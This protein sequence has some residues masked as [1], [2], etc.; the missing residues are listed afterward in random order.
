MS[1]GGVF[2]LIANKGKSDSLL[3][4]TSLLNQRLKQC[5]CSRRENRQA[6]ATP[7]LAD[8]EKTHVLFVNAHFK[9]FAAIGFEYNKVKPQSGSQTYG[10]SVTF[11]IPQFGDFFHDMVMRA[12]L[13]SA[14]ASQGALAATLHTA[15]G[16]FHTNAATD[17]TRL[18]KYCDHPGN[19]LAKKVKFD[20]NGNPLDEYVDMTSAMI[21]KFTVAPGKRAGYNR[22]TGQEN[23]IV[24]QGGLMHAATAA[25][26]AQDAR[27]QVKI[28]NGLQTPKGAHAAVTVWHKLRFWFND[29]C[30]LAVPS[31]SIPYGQRFITIDLASK[32]D[33]LEEIENSYDAATIS[34]TALNGVAW[35]ASGTALSASAANVTLGN[36]SNLTLELYVNNI[37][38][39][40]EVHDIFIKRIGFSL[41]RVY[42]YHSAAANPEVSGEMLMSSLKWPIE[43][44]WVG[45]QQ[46]TYKT[47]AGRSQN[48]HR[49]SA[50]TDVT[51]GGSGVFTGSDDNGAVDDEFRFT[52]ESPQGIQYK[53]STTWVNKLTVKAHGITLYDDFESAFYNSYIP[54]HYGGAAIQTPD[55][56][57]GVMMINFALYPG[58]AYQP[59]GHINVSRAREFYLSWTGVT[60]GSEDGTTVTM[61]AV[62]KA[63]NFLL[64]TDGSAVLRY[65]T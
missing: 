32:G 55:Q 2:Q 20:V 36:S 12:D 45:F 62:A 29:D 53:T 48:W 6:D 25:G 63:L 64:I 23:A 56:D 10:G 43:Y 50:L 21:E 17:Y 1:A 18:V 34:G 51:S 8:I 3:L 15:S 16:T 26:T 65:S 5:A 24:G 42:R 11:S 4:A 27:Q 58:S 49:F 22:L 13:P 30:R 44:M 59:S 40:P 9:P 39:N 60:N 7:T 35:A 19:R 47:A 31:V 46:N 54:F 41:I 38:V 37:F 33:M 57:D 61:H 14:T 28:L 52:N